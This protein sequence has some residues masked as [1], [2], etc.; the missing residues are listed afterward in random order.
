MLT[1]ALLAVLSASGSDSNQAAIVYSRVSPKVLTVSCET[2]RGKSQGSAVIVGAGLV[3]TNFHVI[4]GAT[5]ITVRRG[6][7]SW[8]AQAI[9]VD[10]KKDLALL[11]VTDLTGPAVKLGALARVKIGDPVYAIGSPRGLDLTLTNGLVSA[12]RDEEGQRV[13]QT[14]APISPG[15]SGGGLFDAAGQLIGITTA[16]AGE[17]LGFAIPVDAVAELLAGD[18]GIAVSPTRTSEWSV[19]TRPPGLSCKLDTDLIWGL[20][21]EGPEI[22]ERTAV[23]R[24]ALIVQFDTIEPVMISDDSKRVPLVT[25]DLNRTEQTISFSAPETGHRVHLTFEPENDSIHFVH[26][27]LAEYKGVPRLLTREG[28]CQPE[29]RE[30]KSAGVRSLSMD[31]LSELA[32]LRKSCERGSASSCRDAA[33]RYRGIGD[34]E[35]AKKVA[36]KLSELEK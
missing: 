8:T 9:R 19:T 27:R 29:S 34:A 12:L 5:A 10:E 32:A 25:L 13:I 4:K 36:D 11:R 26:A 28:T 17:G 15:S 23:T 18:G 21:A 1:T 35:N 2:K 22:L 30:T 3:V 16:K 20:F 14:S 31:E 24:S 33:R 6:G 7:T